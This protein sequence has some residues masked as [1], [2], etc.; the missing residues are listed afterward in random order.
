MSNPVSVLPAGVANATRVPAAAK[1][2]GTA[3]A[4]TATGPVTVQTDVM[5]FPAPHNVGNWIL[6]SFRVKAGGVPV[7]HQASVGTS[8]SPSLPPGPMTVTMGDARVK[9]L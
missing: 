8:V 1:V 9:A 7:I 6:G 5:Q 3:R 4:Q 2:P